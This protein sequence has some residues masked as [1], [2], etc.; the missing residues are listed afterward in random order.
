[1]ARAQLVAAGTLFF[2]AGLAS[3]FVSPFASGFV[4]LFAS[5]FVSLFASDFA[6]LS[7]AVAFSAGFLPP[8]K[9]VAYQPL[10]F[11]WKPAA[12]SCLRNFA[13]PQAGHFAIGRS[14]IFWRKSCS[15]PHFPQR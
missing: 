5:D 1:M 14:E 6:A 11:N 8:L 2:A 4:S 13:L 15:C 3:H 7:G 12:L 10:P 9:S